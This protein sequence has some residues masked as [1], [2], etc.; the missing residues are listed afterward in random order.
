MPLTHGNELSS[1]GFRRVM[2]AMNEPQHE[3][4]HRRRRRRQ[5]FDSNGCSEIKR[6]V[7]GCFPD[8]DIPDSTFLC[9]RS[10]H[11]RRGHQVR[12]A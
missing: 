1:S 5:V 6:R 8:S 10:V 9:S 2:P 12:R 11:V 7:D 3:E 4:W